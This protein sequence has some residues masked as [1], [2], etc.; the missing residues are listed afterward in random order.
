M[1][2]GSSKDEEWVRGKHE[3]I[4]ALIGPQFVRG[5]VIARFLHLANSLVLFL[6]D[7]FTRENTHLMSL[8][9]EPGRC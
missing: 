7:L 3:D 6:C 8:L 1:G 2:G 4:L 9:L 5:E